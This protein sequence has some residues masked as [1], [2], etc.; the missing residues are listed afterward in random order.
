MK[1]SNPYRLAAACALF[2]LLLLTGGCATNPHNPDPHQRLN[3]VI[4]GINDI[5][6][7]LIL[8]PLS[9]VYV[10]IVP[11]PIRTGL[12]NAF[13]NLGYLNV[14]LNDF[15]QGK[16][17][18]GLSD[19]GRMAVNTT[20]GV[21]GIFDVAT[22]W[23]MPEH[24]N[25]FGITLARW[26]VKDSGPYLVLPLYGPSTLRDVPGRGVSMVTNPLFWTSIPLAVSIP[27]DAASTAETRARLDD[28][29]KFRD[30][31]AIDPYIFMRDGYLQRRRMQVEGGRPPPPG[32][33]FYNDEPDSTPA[34]ATQPALAVTGK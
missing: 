17:D 23:G 9:D 32:D 26:G 8:K 3:R 29:I 21:A 33:D 10:A 11:K 31:A 25:D 34:P 2:A 28:L 13:D 6:D 7:K 5:G 27:L 15:L 14:I 18:Q 20:V 24:E 22:K 16:V 19:T 30:Q 1:S 12:G 4:Y